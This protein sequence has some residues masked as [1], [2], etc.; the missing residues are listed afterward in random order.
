MNLWEFL[1]KKIKVITN[2]KKVFIGKYVSYTQA[3]DNEPEIASITLTT[4]TKEVYYELY[5]NDI[6]K[7]E[8][9]E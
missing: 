1:N 5:E 6:I 9:I 3:L 2:N 8:I 4:E 7:I